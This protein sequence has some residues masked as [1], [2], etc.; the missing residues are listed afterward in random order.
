MFD[1]LD[2]DWFNITLQILFLLFIVYDLRRYLQT[3]KREY[4]INIALT[5]IFFIWAAV[6]FYTKY[7]SWSDKQRALLDTACGM[8]MHDTICRC[9]NDKI[10][11][12][13]PYEEYKD[14]ELTGSQELRNFVKDAAKECK[15]R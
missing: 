1:F 3:K 5:I 10:E 2:E 11:K 8:S 4:I 15:E 9:I 12:E 6:P 14:L 13:Y 7:L